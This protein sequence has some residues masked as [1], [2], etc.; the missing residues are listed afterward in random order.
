M[1][2][3]LKTSDEVSHKLVLFI[4]GIGMFVDAYD[5]FIVS[6]AEPFVRQAFHVEGI[7]LGL[8]QS[9]APLGAAFGALIVGIMADK[10]GRKKLMYLNMIAFVVVSLLSACSWSPVSFIFFRF[11]VGFWVGADYPICASYLAEIAQKKRGQSVAIIRLINAFGYPAG[12][13]VAY[14]VI[15][16]DHGNNSWRWMLLAGCIPAIVG[17]L[18]RTKLPESFVWAAAMRIKTS[19]SGFKTIF[20]K[21]YRKLTFIGSS[22]YALKDISEYGIHLFMPTILLALGVSK[23]SDPIQNINNA[24]I[25]TM[26]SG[27]TIVAGAICARLLI[28]RMDRKVFQR[29]FFIL[30]ALF[31]IALGLGGVFPLL[32]T[33]TFIIIAFIAYNFFETITGTTTYLIP[34]EIYETS[35]RAT[36]HGFVS[37]MGKVGAF[38]GVSFLPVLEHFAGIHITVAI[39]AIPL[40][41]G[42]ILS[43][44][45]PRGIS[46]MNLS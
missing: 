20:S 5:L 29:T 42:S 13:I 4:C 35:V 19:L 12:A 28:N 27:F 36:G 6:L 15:Q 17:C 37:S 16:F 39:M 44:M 41:L 45:Y 9:A 8:M 18:L 2:I 30:A 1:N 38:I 25:L 22:C 10:F 34:A 46:Q 26:F 23:S 40:I 33:P 21:K 32:A 43:H 7:L 14:L 31:L 24:F 11:C 3:S